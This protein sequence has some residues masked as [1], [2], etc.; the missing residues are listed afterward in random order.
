V[1]NRE[2]RETLKTTKSDFLGVSLKGNRNIDSHARILH[3][4]FAFKPKTEPEPCARS[5]EAGDASGSER[6]P[7]PTKGTGMRKPVGNSKTDA[8]ASANE[9]PALRHLLC[10]D[11]LVFST[12][13]RK[14]LLK[15]IGLLTRHLD[16]M[17]A[18][19]AVLKV[20]QIRLEQQLSSQQ[21]RACFPRVTR[22]PSS[23]RDAQ[24]THRPPADAPEPPQP[25]AAPPTTSPLTEDHVTAVRQDRP[26]TLPGAAA[27]L[28]LP[29]PPDPTPTGIPTSGGGGGG[30]ISTGPARLGAAGAR[31]GPCPPVP[32]APDTAGPPAPAPAVPY[33]VLIRT[34]S[35]RSP[36]PPPLPPHPTTRPPPPQPRNVSHYCCC[37][38]AGAADPAPACRQ[39]GTDA[40]VSLGLRGALR[41]APLVPL[42]HDPPRG[43]ALHQPPGAPA[44]LAAA[45]GG[46]A[47]AAAGEGG[48]VRMERGGLVW[49][50]VESAAGDLGELREA[51]PP[52]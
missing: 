20:Q 52:L 4:N 10:T 30:A 24:A 1:E 46:R 45:A 26:E 48:A 17:E 15:D 19:T 42:R 27:A 44:P 23:R 28:L 51:R 22:P 3:G 5:T 14:V 35:C 18:D 16:A 29:P 50:R 33:D 43:V 32:P 47:A 13:S 12:Y 9:S 41:H 2:L 31:P 21:R 38:A 36:C 49:L 6:R 8:S 40:L 25:P 34:G 7:S 11:H 39:A 37:F